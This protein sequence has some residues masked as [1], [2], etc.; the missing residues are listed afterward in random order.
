MIGG[1]L[2]Y[3]VTNHGILSFAELKGIEVIS[4]VPG[5]S[6]VLSFYKGPTRRE[7]TFV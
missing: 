4:F 2:P 5:L 3:P 1:L 7:S 6:E